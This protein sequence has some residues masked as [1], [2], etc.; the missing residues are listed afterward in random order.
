MNSTLAFWLIGAC[1]LLLC[2]LYF[3]KGSKLKR[4]CTERVYASIVKVDYQHFD[5]R[6]E[7]I[8]IYAYRVNGCDYEAK[9]QSSSSKRKYKVGTESFV[10]YNPA[11][12]SDCLV[13]GKNSY[14]KAGFVFAIIAAL[15]IA[16]AL[17]I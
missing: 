16:F 7:Y 8:P 4:T 14:T 5:K 9:G 15:F 17:F 11:K 13:E 6:R 1:C 2:I 3:V 10:M 12:P